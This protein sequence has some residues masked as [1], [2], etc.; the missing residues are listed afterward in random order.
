MHFR[1]FVL[2]NKTKLLRKVFILA[3]YVRFTAVTLRLSAPIKVALGPSFVKANGGSLMNEEHQLFI[4]Q[5]RPDQTRS[6][7]IGCVTFVQ[8]LLTSRL[9]RR[10]TTNDV[11]INAA[12][13]AEGRF[14]FICLCRIIIIITTTTTTSADR[15][16]NNR[17][18]T[19][20]TNKGLHHREARR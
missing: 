13:R 20:L 19:G 12:R 18:E 3:V 2:R 10:K 1:I 4:L 11:I 9:N 15:H 14:I 5:S 7:R 17:F 16:T 6:D 8:T